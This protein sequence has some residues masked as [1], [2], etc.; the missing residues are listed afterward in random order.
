M[1]VAARLGSVVI[2]ATLVFTAPTLAAEATN[3]GWSGSCQ[4]DTCS[5]RLQS[6][7]GQEAL[8][9][10][11]R[12][13]ANGN[14]IAVGFETPI[15]NADRSRP[16]TLRLDG[17]AVAT[18]RPASDYASTESA[19]AF[20]IVKADLADSIVTKLVRA[21][22][23]RIEYL[24]ILGAPHDADFALAGLAP[25]LEAMDAGS[26]DRL[27]AAV[28]PVATGFTAPSRFDEIRRLGPPPR[29]MEM[30]ARMTT[31]EALDSPRLAQV[32]PVVAPLPPTAM[33]YALPCTAQ[34]DTVSYRLWTVDFGEIGGIFPLSFA[35]HQPARG[36]I[37]TELLPNVAFDETDARLTARGAPA[38]G[39]PFEAHWR[40]RDHGFTME[41]FT[42]G[43]CAGLKSATKVYP[44]K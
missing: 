18:L 37:G 12:P 14:G 26:A 16:I 28:P 42:A 5:A 13:V 33:L 8:V 4:P 15:V 44:P 7:S 1:S 19:S 3:S 17:K 31:C 38:G 41:D 40:W 21:T 22:S 34:R 35:L 20:W 23:L 32:R 27:R 2:A 30:H 9:L 36:W 43:P 39:C 24:D 6:A 10:S 25:Q 29:L 11:R